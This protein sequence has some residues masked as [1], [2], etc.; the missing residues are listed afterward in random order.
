[1]RLPVR[2]LVSL[3]DRIRSLRFPEWTIPF[4]LIG[5]SACTYGPLVTRLGFYWEDW[6]VLW[7]FETLGV[8]GI[9]D[10]FA[11]ERPVFGWVYSW[12]VPNLGV[13]PVP[14]HV[15]ALLFR[16]LAAVMLWSLLK[17]LWTEKRDVA[18]LSGVVFAVYPGYILQPIAILSS[19]FFF[20]YVLEIG[21]LAAMVWVQ[22]AP[23]WSILLTVAALLAAAATTLM[24]EYFVGLELLRPVLLWMVLGEKAT[25][26]MDRGVRVA[27]AWAPYALALGVYTYWRVF[28]FTPWMYDVKEIGLSIARDPLA[29]VWMR[30]TQIPLNVLLGSLSPWA[31]LFDSQVT[32]WGYVSWRIAA[33]GLVSGAVY[34]WLSRLV[35][36]RTI[37]L[38]TGGDPD[39]EDC[40]WSPVMLGL[41]AMVFAGIPVWFSGRTINLWGLSNRLVLPL[42]VGASL[43]MA[44]SL[45]AL[46]RTN[47][48]RVAAV[49]ILAGLAVGFHLSNGLRFQENWNTQRQMAWQ[50]AWRIPSLAPGAALVAVERPVR[51][52]NDYIMSFQAN[53]LYGAP[54]KR[55]LD[56]WVFELSGEGGG[57]GRSPGTG[58]GLEFLRKDFLLERD[59]RFV[60]FRGS[61]ERSL[62][63]WYAHPRCLTVLDPEKLGRDDLPKL[64]QQ[65]GRISD[66]SL[67]LAPDR[68]KTGVEKFFW[69][70]PE[71]GWCYYFQKAELARQRGKWEEVAMLGDDA[72]RR[73]HSTAFPAEWDVFL[74]AYV[75][76][77]R[78]EDV[79][80][81][82]GRVCKDKILVRPEAC[83]DVQS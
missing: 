73:K 78:E 37:R 12:T 38:K 35:L 52:T 36:P 2:V 57:G 9:R 54:G 56:H 33:M 24:N 32:P 72:R 27:R 1:M 42:M 62:A 20:Q 81:I 46:I 47:R 25:G 21:S 49:S 59:Y 7:A 11:N 41:L 80:E 70:E 74:E 6:Q 17:G 28:L 53:L 48:Q 15:L 79:R 55:A 34:M 44:G 40:G 71:H 69:P 4:F 51:F 63:F 61:A 77:G 75:R 58:K 5:L 43:F 13:S 19:H 60:R 64:A 22:R 18:V 83:R 45:V 30:F 29:E 39:H 67:V 65:V 14:Y 68:A 50:L 26:A 8:Q 76:L 23:R 3:Y 16:G 10:L 82:A 31:A 66:L